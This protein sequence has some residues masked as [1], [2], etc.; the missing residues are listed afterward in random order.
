M[1]YAVAEIRRTT[2]RLLDLDNPDHVS[3]N[4]QQAFEMIRASDTVG[5]FQL[6]SVS[7]PAVLHSFAVAG[8][9]G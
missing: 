7:T 8:A 3:L 2:G 5:L 6:D 4:D 1:A 9:R